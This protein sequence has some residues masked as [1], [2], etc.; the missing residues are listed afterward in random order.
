MTGAQETPTFPNSPLTTTATEP[1]PDP[2]VIPSIHPFRTLVLCFDGTGDKFQN[3]SNVA[4]F[5]SML[6]KN[7]PTKQ[8]VYYQ[9]GIGT[10]TSHKYLTSLATWASK[11]FDMMWAR[12]LDDHIMRGY[13]FIMQN[14]RAG[15]RICIFGFSRG[16]YTARCLAGMIREVGV[17]PAWNYEQVPFAFKIYAKNDR[18]EAQWFKEDFSIDVDIEMVGVW[19]TVASVGAIPRTLPFTSSNT[20]VKTF[21]HAL[22][23]D[24]RRAKFQPNLWHT[25]T[26]DS[27]V[28]TPS[29]GIERREKPE[30]PANQG[31]NTES[32]MLKM[33]PWKRNYTKARDEDTNV[34]EVWF[35]GAHCDVGGGSVQGQPRYSLARIPLRWMIRECFRTNSGIMFGHVGLKELGLDP[36]SLY[37]H[38]TR[39]YPKEAYSSTPLLSL[40]SSQGIP[41]VI[42]KRATDLQ[43]PIQ[44]K[45]EKEEIEEAHD[46]LSPAYDQLSLKPWR[47]CIHEI[48]PFLTGNGR[49]SRH[50][51]LGRGRRIPLPPLGDRIKV[52]RSVHT[53]K[54]AEL[55]EGPGRWTGLCHSRQQKPEGP[56]KY[57][58]RATMD[59]DTVEWVD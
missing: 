50:I 13:E 17:L 5:F 8:M 29:S 18:K 37:D 56:V 33:E 59:W 25:N 23:L 34:K 58:P 28:L 52:H 24:E 7:D 27:A 16:A 22:S 44:S 39:T 19:D 49:W 1:V 40:P 32:D 38:Q 53:R 9:P 3:H 54:A 21:R 15:D 30:D 42:R 6:K 51:N 12:S 57:Q 10:Y 2:D 48:F 36:K 11:L 31:F 43:G 4:E 45:I 46:A 20:I 26:E 47:W 14:Y 55:S 41:Q 35:A